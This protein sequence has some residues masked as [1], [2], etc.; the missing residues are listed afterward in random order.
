M[1]E[2]EKLSNY[3]QSVVVIDSELDKYDDTDIFKEKNDSAFAFLEKNPVPARLLKEMQDR[4]IKR[5]FEQNMSIDQ[6]AQVLD[7][8][9]TEVLAAL[10]EMGLVEPVIS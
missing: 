6:I 5:R 8:P 4:R 1:V 2:I 10:E 9:K 7:L 3:K